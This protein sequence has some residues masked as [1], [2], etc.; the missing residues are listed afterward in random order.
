MGKVQK[1][2]IKHVLYNLVGIEKF[3]L[4]RK[5]EEAKN[6]TSEL[7]KTSSNITDVDKSVDIANF[8]IPSIPIHILKLW[9]GVNFVLETIISEVASRR[10]DLAPHKNV[11]H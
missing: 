6:H 8:K 10:K 9:S 11:F 2:S 5:K 3:I 4:I 7:L 1:I